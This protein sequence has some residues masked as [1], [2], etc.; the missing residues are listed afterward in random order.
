MNLDQ[1]RSFCLLFPYVTEEFPFNETTLVFKVGGKM[2]LLVDIHEAEHIT[3][4]SSPSEVEDLTERYD[5]ITRGF[6]MNKTH[7]LTLDLSSL[8]ASRSIVETLMLSSYNLVYQGLTK[9]T[10]QELENR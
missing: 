5:W 2:F 9:K 4:K 7:W 8:H 6:H 3:L 1:I 10:R